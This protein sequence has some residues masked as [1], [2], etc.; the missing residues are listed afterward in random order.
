MPP[1]HQAAE[2]A[3]WTRSVITTAGDLEREAKSR[4]QN[5]LE[6]FGVMVFVLTML[7]PVGYLF[8]VLM[9]SNAVNVGVN[10][11]LVLGGI[12]LLF[13]APFLHKDTA[14]SWGLGN[15]RA[16]GRMLR[17]SPPARQTLLIAIMAALFIGLNVVNFLRWNDVVRFFNFNQLARFFGAADPRMQT[18]NHSFPGVLFVF[19]FGAALSLVIITCAIRYDNFLSAF[20]TA[21]IISLPLLLLSF[22]AAYLHRGTAAFQNISLGKWTLGVFGYVFWGFV[23]QLLFSSYFGTRFRKA[24]APSRAPGN[25]IPPDQRF[26]LTVKFALA[27]GLT[28]AVLAFAAIR[29][30]YGPGSFNLQLLAWVAGFLAPLGAVYGYFYCL[31]KKRLLVATLSASCFGLIHIDSYGL[32]AV[33][34]GLGIVLVYVFMEDKNRNLVALGFVHGLLGSTFG[35]LFSKGDAGVLEIDYS[36]GP[37]NIEHPTALAMIFPMLCIAVYLAFMA[38]SIRNIHETDSA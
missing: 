12:Y 31:D 9:D 22:L 15:P 1:T 34:W 38:W 11:T 23:Q 3:P 18:L 33:T 24:F 10:I 14:E 8:G 7:W 36:V 6:G 25:V 13:I 35:T 21:L 32:V 19:S 30:L 26:A 29:A 2:S 37:W 17:D 20:R 28:G 27:F 5:A 4:V 16:L